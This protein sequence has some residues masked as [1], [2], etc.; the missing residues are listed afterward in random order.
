MSDLGTVDLDDSADA[1]PSSQRR[2]PSLV[3]RF[4]LNARPGIATELGWP[5]LRF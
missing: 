3:M 2:N 5:L 1:K 4:P